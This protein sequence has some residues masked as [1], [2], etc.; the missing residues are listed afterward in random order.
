M[1]V[2]EISNR[3]SR[4]MSTPEIRAMLL[5]ALTLLVTRVDADDP[6]RAVAA[7]HLAL[8]AHLLD[9]RSN[10]H[11]TSFA[12]GAGARSGGRHCWG[13]TRGRLLVAIG[14]SPS[15][16]VVGSELD[17]HLVAGCD[18]DV[19]HAHLAGDVSEHLVPV[20]QLDTEHGIRQRFGDGAFHQD[21][22]VF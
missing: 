3:F 10:L 11:R 22:V 19:I 14:D 1:Y 4:G 18:A 2:S 6:H 17:L 7:D 8:V 20:L 16:E 13:R 5:L 15:G 9:R 12:G 21:H